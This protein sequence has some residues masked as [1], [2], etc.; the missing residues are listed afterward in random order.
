M[1]PFR[2]QSHDNVL[3]GFAKYPF[4]FCDVAGPQQT[5]PLRNRILRV[6]PRGP[7]PVSAV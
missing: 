5:L 2:E 3:L 6:L 7:A 4:S 1:N